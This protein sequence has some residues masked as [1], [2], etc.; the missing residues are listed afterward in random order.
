MPAFSNMTYAVSTQ[1]SQFGSYL[2][3]PK[4]SSF[5]ILALFPK[6]P[7]Y[8][9]SLAVFHHT[10]ICPVIFYAFE[11]QLSVDHHTYIFDSQLRDNCMSIHFHFDAVL[12]P[13]I[14]AFICYLP[15]VAK[16]LLFRLIKHGQ[17]I[18]EADNHGRTT[19]VDLVL[20]FVIPL[21]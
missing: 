18:Y 5:F 7:S 17:V 16:C 12:L 11:T 1:V 10:V 19:V 3:R 13:V 20:K 21:L 6:L 2:P 4:F 15:P 14:C 9:R 8:K